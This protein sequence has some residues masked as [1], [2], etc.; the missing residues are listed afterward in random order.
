MK[1]KLILYY[2][3]TCPYCQKVIRYMDQA[4]IKF[5][6]ANISDGYEALQELINVGGKR[7]VP[8]LFIDDKAL[9]ESD[10]IIEWFKNNY[11]E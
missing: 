9:Y 10:D 3:P 2:K 4:N 5:P 11:K 8:C 7:Q 6:L 1:N